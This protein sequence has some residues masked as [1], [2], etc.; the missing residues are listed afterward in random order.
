M[1]AARALPNEPFDDRLISQTLLEDIQID[2]PD[3]DDEPTGDPTADVEFVPKAPSLPPSQVQTLEPAPMP[4]VE[5]ERKT[6]WLRW[7]LTALGAAAVLALPFLSRP[8][9]PQ[10]T[11]VP[12]PIEVG[13]D[14]VDVRG[15]NALTLK[16]GGTRIRLPATVPAGI[17]SVETTEGASLR[18]V[19]SVELR[20][21]TV[22]LACTESECTVD[23]VE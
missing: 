9:P 14:P 3:Q 2:A 10:K 22:R 1:E 13:G 16:R 20:P 5:P 11:F 12:A 8:S 15:S 4:S 21:G 18:A 7:T 23:I 6:P 19:D 17:W